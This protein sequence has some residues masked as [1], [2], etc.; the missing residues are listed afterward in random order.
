MEQVRES[1]EKADSND[2]GGRVKFKAL[3]NAEKKDQ[4]Q[5]L[6]NFK[7]EQQILLMAKRKKC[8]FKMQKRKIEK[9]ELKRAIILGENTAKGDNKTNTKN[10]N[11]EID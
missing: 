5:L 11:C 1:E 4:K 9:W 10:K 7:D 3:E 8:K 6:I 2:K